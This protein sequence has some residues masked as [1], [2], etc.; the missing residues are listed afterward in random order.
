MK[1]RNVVLQDNIDISTAS[2]KVIGI[3][4]NDPIS[5]LSFKFNI[6][7]DATTPVIIAH[8]ARAVSKIEVIDGGHI[9]ASLSAEEL[10]AQNYYDH[11][12]M[13]C[14]YLNGVT[15]TQS[16]F[17]ADLDFGRWLW[18]NDLALD[19]KKYSNPQIRIVYNKALYES[20]SDA[21]YMTILA[22][23][24][25]EKS[26][27]P[28]GYIKRHE[29]ATWTPSSS[30]TDYIT[31]PTDFPIRALFA[32]GYSTTTHVRAQIAS[33]KITEDNGKK[34]PYELSTRHYVSTLM[35]DYPAIVEPVIFIGS[36]ST[37]VLYTMASYEGQFVGTPTAA[38][39]VFLTSYTADTLTVDCASGSNRIEGI[40]RG[41]VPFHT[42]PVYFGNRED[43]DDWYD[44]K[45]V[46]DL[47][48]QSTAGTVGTSPVGRITLE[49]LVNF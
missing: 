16:Y 30:T 6:Q 14:S 37:E 1:Y 34:V 24:F 18:D 26:P 48:F 33:M 11:K 2:T 49:Q 5:R 28:R 39:D 35:T 27:A 31:L 38:E 12:R 9:I 46:G 44:L 36:T 43:I 22:D 32:A 3:N 4:I 41:F 8:P 19:P 20:S 17:M 21:M 15:N 45:N 47:E 25:D 13:P 10:L 29:I 7:N 42:I 23:V 40:A